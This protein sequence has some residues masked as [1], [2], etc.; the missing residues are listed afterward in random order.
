MRRI[1][2]LIVTL[3]MLCFVSPAF[4]VMSE[5]LDASDVAILCSI[6]VTCAEIISPY[7]EPEVRFVD[8]SVY[9]DFGDIWYD[10]NLSPI[11]KKF[12]TNGREGII[13]LYETFQITGDTPFSDWDEQLYVKNCAGRWEVSDDYDGLYWN[14]A[15]S[16]PPGTVTVDE[17]IDLVTIEWDPALSPYTTVTLHK[18]IHVPACMDRFAV[19]EWPTVPDG[20]IPEPTISAIAGIMMLGLL[21]V[22]RKQS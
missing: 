5:G 15:E 6:E 14:S 7:G 21:V 10:E 12:C 20:N 19:M 18:T 16:L 8:D 13:H 11:F 4:S 17:P 3:F 22:R 2:C 1:V 9:I